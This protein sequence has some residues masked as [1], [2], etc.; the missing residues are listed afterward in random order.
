[1]IVVTG[2]GRILKGLDKYGVIDALKSAQE[3]GDRF[4]SITGAYA[5]GLDPAEIEKEAGYNGAT[6]AE[7]IRDLDKKAGI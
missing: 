2:D 5:E 7:T 3:K 6:E 4:A 1:M